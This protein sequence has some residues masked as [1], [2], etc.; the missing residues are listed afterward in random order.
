M[1]FARVL[2]RV[3]ANPWEARRRGAE[4]EGRGVSLAQSWENRRGCERV[5]ASRKPP[6][7]HEP[8]LPYRGE[9]A[10]STRRPRQSAAALWYPLRTC[11]W[12]VAVQVQRRQ[13]RWRS[14]RAA[15]AT[16]RAQPPNV[17]RPCNRRTDVGPS[18]VGYMVGDFACQTAASGVSVPAIFR[19][20]DESLCHTGV[21]HG[22][23]YA[24]RGSHLFTVMRPCR[25][26]AALSVPCAVSSRP[27]A[28]CY[29]SHV[30][31]P[32]LLR[33][34]LVGRLVTAVGRL[35]TAKCNPFQDVDLWV[36]HEGCIGV[37]AGGIHFCCRPNPCGGARGF[38]FCCRPRPC[39]P[40]RSTRR[41]DRLTSFL[42][43][44]LGTS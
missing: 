43:P 24:W 1:L 34:S 23:V 37:G 20:H 2:A 18:G 42:Q 27:R 17:R 26:T 15:A 39:G 4:A 6:P 14:L 29:A 19:F 32:F 3:R 36:C 31:G 7:T 25:R 41:S 35:A 5:D 21:W 28:Q 44:E 30:C 11:S 33:A 16:R 10:L 12:G 38:R 22:G 40:P 13:P 8:R 9:G